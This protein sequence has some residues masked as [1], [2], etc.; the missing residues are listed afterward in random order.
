MFTRCS[1]DVPWM[2]TE[3]S[4]NDSPGGCIPGW[5][6]VPGCRGGLSPPLSGCCGC[7]GACSASARAPL[8]APP[9]E[10]RGTFREDSGNSQGTLNS[11]APPVE[12]LGNI[13]GTFSEHAGNFQGTFT[14]LRR[15]TSYASGSKLHAQGTFREHSGNMQGT[16]QEN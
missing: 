4:L 9:V 11:V 1:L 15:R 10:Q 14:L 12:H 3:C 16:S 8:R 13:Q 7:R 6:A 2:F 5:G